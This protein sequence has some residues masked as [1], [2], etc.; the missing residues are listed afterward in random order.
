V[1]GPLDDN[2]L[3]TRKESPYVITSDL[4]VSKGVT[5]TIEAGVEVRFAASPETGRLFQP[6]G[7]EGQTPQT[8]LIIRGRLAA[9]GQVDAPVS[10]LG[11]KGAAWGGVIFMAGC[12]DSSRME[13]CR[14]EGGKVVFNAASP[15]LTHSHLIGSGVEVGFLAAPEVAYNRVEGGEAGILSLS[16]S[17]SLANVHHNLVAGNRYGLYLKG[18]AETGLRLNTFTDNTE[19]DVINYT[20]KAAD[21]SGNYWGGRKEEAIRKSIYDAHSNKASGPVIVTPTAK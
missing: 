17:S 6:V 19:F 1:S 18:F 15:S 14:V 8:D 2:T 11:E 3:W 7:F 5:L 16:G 12:D 10:F 9:L 20:S 21:V 4:T 13:Y